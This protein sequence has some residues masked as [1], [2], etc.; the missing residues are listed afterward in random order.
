MSFIKIEKKIKK[1]DKN[2]T[3]S[4]DKSL[5]IRWAL[6]ASQSPYKSKSYNL[7]ASEDVLNT[8]DCLK[9]LGVKIKLTKKFCEIFGVGLNGFKYK[10]RLSLNAG[11]SGT[12]GRLIMGLLVHCNDSIILKG[13]KSLSRRDFLRITKPLERFGAKFKTNSG[14]LPISIKGTDNPS[15]ISYNETRGSAQCKSAVMLAALNT[16]GETTIKAKKSRDHSELLFK[17]LKLPIKI[18]KKKNYDLIRIKGKK[19][20]PSINYRIP[21]DISSSAF[22][23]VLTALSENSKL[24]IKNININPSRTG[25]LSILKMMKVKIKI[26]NKRVY[27]GERIADLLIHGSKKFRSINCPIKF[28][29]AAIDEF[30]LIFLVAAKANGISFF[31]NLSELNEKESPRLE[32]GSKILNKIGIKN[33]VTKNSIKIYGNPN[34]EVDKKIVIKNFLKDHRVFMTSVV[35]ALTLGGKWQIHDKDSINTSFPSFLNKMN[36]LG[37]KIKY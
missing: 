6:L 18:K 32:W 30:L 19:I 27:K 23:I 1:F 33:I 16:K 36:Y 17:Y 25:I 5:S 21:A 26:I 22:F 9:K 14:K 7:L 10:K 15:P 24:R 11:N 29:S 34:I 28:N 20:I 31:K 4:G 3:T 2:L 12:L 13:D 35:A 8:I 37:A